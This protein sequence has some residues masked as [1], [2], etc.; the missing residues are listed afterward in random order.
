MRT[1]V[2]EQP[3]DRP[4]RAGQRQQDEAVAKDAVRVVGIEKTSCMKTVPM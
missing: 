2:T 3:D 1:L 4:C